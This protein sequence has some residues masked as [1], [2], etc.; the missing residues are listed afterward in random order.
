M[1]IDVALVVAMLMPGA[2]AQ[3]ANLTRYEFAGGKRRAVTDTTHPWGGVNLFRNVASLILWLVGHSLPPV[4]LRS[5]R[6]ANHNAASRGSQVA[7]ARRRSK[8]NGKSHVGNGAS[9]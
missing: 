1:T 4:V 6:R 7:G 3:F 8:P 9:R 2:F 5:E